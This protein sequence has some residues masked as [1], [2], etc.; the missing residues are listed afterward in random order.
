VIQ[1]EER[2]GAGVDGGFGICCVTAASVSFKDGYNSVLTA[3]IDRRHGAGAF[4]SL[5]EESRRQS[6]E[7]LWDAKQLWLKKNGLAQPNAGHETE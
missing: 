5:L 6:E 7:S 1:L 3:E 2:C 4:Q